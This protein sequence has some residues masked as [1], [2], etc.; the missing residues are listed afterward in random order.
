MVKFDFE[1][2]I[3]DSTKDKVGV[4]YIVIQSYHKGFNNNQ[5]DMQQA[6][7]SFT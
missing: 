5:E 7:L 3:P 2:T 1:M 6:I 4:I